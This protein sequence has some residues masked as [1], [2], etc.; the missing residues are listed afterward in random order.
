MPAIPRTRAEREIEVSE[1]VR[2]FKEK[3]TIY[4]PQN[5]AQNDVVL[6]FVFFNLLSEMT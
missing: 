6:C 1:R 3:I 5:L 2:V 4:T